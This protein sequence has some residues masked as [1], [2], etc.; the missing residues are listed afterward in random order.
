[1]VNDE[2]R[3]VFLVR[4]IL[5]KLSQN[6]RLDHTLVDNGPRREGSDINFM[7]VLPDEPGVF[8]F[9]QE[10]ASNEVKGAFKS[11]SSTI[12]VG[13]QTSGRIDKELPNTRHGAS[14]HR[15]Q[16][17]GIDR[18]F[19][20]SHKFQFICST[21]SLDFLLYSVSLLLIAGEEDHSYTRIRVLLRAKFWEQIPW[22][23]GHNTSTISRDTV[24]ST[25]SS[26]FHAGQRRQ[27]F[28]DHLVCA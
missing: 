7:V 15:S 9:D 19:S 14:G 3:S 20:P 5:V 1:M 2:L 11:I 10:T 12:V 26:V 16:D 25:G 8:E 6:S 23:L 4:Q 28:C 21:D 18:D 13:L 24:A 17:I 22:D 27:T